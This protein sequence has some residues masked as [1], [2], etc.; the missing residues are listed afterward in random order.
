MNKIE[1]LVRFR[2]LLWALIFIL[3]VWGKYSFSSIGI[4]NNCFPTKIENTSSTIM[5]Q[6][7]GIRSDEWAVQVPIFFSQKYNDYKQWCEC[8]LCAP[9]Y[10]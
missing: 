4:Y 3:L 1:G 10:S 8:H 5:G 7:R 2:W 9:F 6:P